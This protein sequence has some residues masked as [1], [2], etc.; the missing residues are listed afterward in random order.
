MSVLL[1]CGGGGGRI[2]IPGVGE[3]Q[4]FCQLAKHIDRIPGLDG[5]GG[6]GGTELKPLSKSTRDA[7]NRVLQLAPESLRGDLRVVVKG[8]LEAAATRKPNAV[9]SLGNDERFV[10]S[11]KR[12][13]NKME[14]LCGFVPDLDGIPG[15]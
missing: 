5:K 6:G 8:L 14:S 15:L 9:R 4:L 2:P 13:G 3:A 1:A 10:R 11:A 12:L 7:M